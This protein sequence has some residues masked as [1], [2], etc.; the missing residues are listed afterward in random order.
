MATDLVTFSKD[1]INVPIALSCNYF[2]YRWRVRGWDAVLED[3]TKP[4]TTSTNKQM[5][6]SNK[7]LRRMKEK[8]TGS[9]KRAIKNPPTPLNKRKRKK[10]KKKNQVDTADHTREITALLTVCLQSNHNFPCP[11]VMII[12]D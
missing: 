3:K 5:Q 2:K 1:E 7:K 11:S 4:R 6:G 9:T 12:D 8:M 10:R